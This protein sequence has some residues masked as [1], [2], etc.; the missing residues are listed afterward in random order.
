MSRN[1][2]RRMLILKK[3]MKTTNLMR[4]RKNLKTNIRTINYV[5][6]TH[7]VVNFYC[8]CIVLLDTYVQTFV[9]MLQNIHLHRQE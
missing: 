4:W 6:K 8:F 1:S 9:K 7:Y 2:Q 3:I 5:V